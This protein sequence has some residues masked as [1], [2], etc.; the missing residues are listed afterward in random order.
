MSTVSAIED[1]K[2]GAGALP[3]DVL[4]VVLQPAQ[5]EADADDAGAHDH[6]GGEHRFARQRRVVL[7]M[8][9]HR[10]DHRRLDDR[11]GKGQQQRAV[12]LAD[13]PRDRLG[14][15][16]DDEHRREDEAGDREQRQHLGP[17]RPML[18]RVRAELGGCREGERADREQILADR[19]PIRSQARHPFLSSAVSRPPLI[20]RRTRSPR[21]GPATLLT[22]RH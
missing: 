7:A 3:L 14:V 15:M 5:R 18:D 20:W 4:V 21:R 22:K 9:H 11:H 12:G 13:P 10:D 1:G 6:H 19:P 8:Q 16:Q 17:E 2:I